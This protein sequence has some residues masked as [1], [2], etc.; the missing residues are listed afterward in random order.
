MSEHSPLSPEGRRR[1][2]DKAKKA[3]SH[4]AENLADENTFNQIRSVVERTAVGVYTDG[5]TFSG[6]FAYLALLAVFSFFIVAAAIAGS[7][8]DT[9]AGAEIVD[10]FLR[11]VPPS[12]A[13]ALR[14]P[15]S[16][17]MAARTGPLLWLSAA[18]GLWTTASLIETI[19]E[20]LHRAYGVTAQRAFW[21][22]RLGSIGL[23]I[24]SV[25]L[26]MLSLSM[27]FLIAGV[28]EFIDGYF[29][30][31][32]TA[33]FWLAISRALPFFILFGTLYMLFRLLTPRNYRSPHYP[34][35]PGAVFISVWW[36]VITGILPLFLKY[37]AN[38]KLTYGSLAGV[39]ITLIFFYLIGL[40]MVIGAQL[41]AALAETRVKES[42][43]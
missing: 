18:V 15:V 23:I 14:D 32:E 16:D 29:P 12:V 17:A 27:Q 35:W 34:K 37:A 36:L 25:I 38:Y 24:V 31:V 11:T 5:F 4:A 21:E 42:A 7:F 43:E 26:A 3:A 40:G 33:S 9:A 28:G 19:R 1:N 39:M 2:P 30:S 10:A 8:G 22:Y 13:N 20:I 41:N 6:N